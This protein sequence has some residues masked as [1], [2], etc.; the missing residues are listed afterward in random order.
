MFCCHMSD[1]MCKHAQ[2]PYHQSHTY[3]SPYLSI[4]IFQHALLPYLRPWNIYMPMYAYTSMLLP[5]TPVILFGCATYWR[6]CLDE[7]LSIRVGANCCIPLFI[8]LCDSTFKLI[9]CLIWVGC[10]VDQNFRTGFSVLTG[11][12][13]S[14]SRHR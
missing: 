12:L 10:F 6:L 2:L 5:C 1:S 9:L 14:F 3:T 8:S 11:E 7:S 4:H 13:P